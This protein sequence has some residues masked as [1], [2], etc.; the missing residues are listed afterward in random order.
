MGALKLVS[1]Y[2]PFTSSQSCYCF[3]VQAVVFCAERMA[4][5][6][7][8][9]WF[10]SLTCVSLLV[11]T[12]LAPSASATAKKNKTAQQ[13]EA[14]ALLDKAATLTDIEAAGSQPFVYIANANWTT[15]SKTTTGL[16]GVAW[17]T[18][19]RYREQISVRR[20][21]QMEIVLKDTL[22]RTRNLESPPLLTE[23]WHGMFE[24]HGLFKDW[25]RKL[26]IEASRPPKELA[27]T[28]NFTCV[29]ADTGI[30]VETVERIACFDN[31]TGLPILSRTHYGDNVVTR[32]FSD[33]ATLGEKHFPREI[34]YSDSIG[35]H[36]ELKSSRL[37]VFTAFADSTFQP[38]PGS[39]S[40]PWCAEPTFKN[41]LKD[42][43]VFLFMQQQPIPF[44]GPDLDDAYAFVTVSAKG[45]A[46]KV[47]FVGKPS[48]FVENNMAN[49]L[50]SAQ[51]LIK[52]CGQQ[53][54]PYEMFV[55]LPVR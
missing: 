28:A 2:T 11:V 20:F 17:Q 25:P 16:F 10:P 46:E 23:R 8:V 34:T 55:H 44:K 50:Y 42:D 39:K 21:T 51:F 31:P 5:V 40:E 12:I 13:I 43:A 36:G 9:R 37:E 33:Y 45:R 19:D 26:K 3:S 29:T 48:N 7:L 52:S 6:T 27:G 47:F 49:R 41:P 22:Y 15:N 14:Q 4:R 54:I 32:T 30:G 1:L 38:A 53:P 24:L 18:V 35:D